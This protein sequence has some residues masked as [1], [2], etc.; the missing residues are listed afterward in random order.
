MSFQYD[1][2]IAKTKTGAVDVDYYYLEARR[3]RSEYLAHLIG[4]SVHGF[5]CF[6]VAILDANKFVTSMFLTKNLVK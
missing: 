3:L 2:E 5:K 1:V 6:C 4:K